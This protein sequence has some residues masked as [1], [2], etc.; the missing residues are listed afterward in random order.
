MKKRRE[1]PVD[2]CLGKKTYLSVKLFVWIGLRE[3]Q[4][5]KSLKRN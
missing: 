5:E 2:I 1:V 4:M 3:T